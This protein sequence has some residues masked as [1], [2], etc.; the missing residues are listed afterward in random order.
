M[1]VEVQLENGRWVGVPGQ[2][3][4]EDGTTAAGKKK[5]KGLPFVASCYRSP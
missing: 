3:D 5:E 1:Y 4:D 2:A